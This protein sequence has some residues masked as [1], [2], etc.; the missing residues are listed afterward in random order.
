MIRRPVESECPFKPASLAFLTVGCDKV[1]V[2][3]A[4]V[5]PG[6]RRWIQDLHVGRD[7]LVSPDLADVG[8][9]LEGRLRDVE[10]MI[11]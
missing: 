6:V 11:S 9:G 8:E 10:L 3:L 1:P 5:L 2:C 4:N 7:V